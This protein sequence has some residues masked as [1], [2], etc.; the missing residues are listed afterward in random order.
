[1]SKGTKYEAVLTYVLEQL[2]SGAWPKGTKVPPLRTVAQEHGCSIST[3]LRVYEHLMARGILQSKPNS[4]FYVTKAP[5][6]RQINLAAVTPNIMPYQAFR[7]SLN[8]AIFHQRRHMFE[9]GD[10]LGAFSFRQTLVKHLQNHSVETEPDQVIITSGT[11][12]TL[13]LLTSMPFPNGKTNVLVEQPTYPG[14][15]HSLRLLGNTVIGLERNSEGIDLDEVERHFR[16]NQI[17]FFYTVSRLSN[18]MG[19]SYSEYERNEIVRLA[20]EH[21]VYIVE[22]D[23]AAGFVI[24]PENLPLAAN[25]FGD[26]VIYL[27]SFSKGF[28]P[29]IRLGFAVIPKTLISQFA[30]WKV[31]AVISPPPLFQQAMEHYIESGK[32]DIH[33]LSMREL[34]R[35]RMEALRRSSAANLPKEVNIHTPD[36][37]VFAAWELPS[38]LNASDLVRECAAAGVELTDGCAFRIRG[39][40]RLVRL[41][42]IG[43]EPAE[44]EAGVE[45]AAR[46]TKHLLRTASANPTPNM[47]QYIT[48]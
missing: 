18:P 11:Q 39:G 9:Y 25:D 48:V 8:R 20:R 24:N 5:N 46:I 13:H 34:Y 41:S 47:N 7:D 33:L 19:Y 6:T 37:G 45:L 21:D 26:R 44:I 35:S 29:G 2:D 38:G 36:E 27:G 15:L 42:V 14:M 10:P 40:N 30:S 32:Y 28:M 43:V 17:K 22:D 4:G 3:V 23:Y 31:A 16:S 12:H 1:M